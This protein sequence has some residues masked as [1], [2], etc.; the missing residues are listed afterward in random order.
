MR[1]TLESLFFGLAL[2]AAMMAQ[3]PVV[4]NLACAANSGSPSAYA[5]SMPAIPPVYAPGTQYAFQ[6]DVA[7]TGVA[8]INFNSL[9]ARTIK[10]VQGA[11]TADLAANDIRGG[12]WVVMMYDGNNMQMLSQLGNTAGGGSAQAVTVST[13]GGLYSAAYSSGGTISGTGT[14]S[15]GSF[16]GGGSGA[17][18]T[19]NVSSGS[20][21]S[22]TGITAG[23]GYTSA[24]TS[25]TAS[26]GTATCSGTITITSNIAVSVTASGIYRNSTPGGSLTYVLPASSAGLWFDIG[27]YRGVS[28]AVAIVAP[29]S[30]YIAV[31][32]SG[33]SSGGNLKS[34]GALG[35]RVF[36]QAI[37]NTTYEASTSVTSSWSNN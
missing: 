6:A 26:S 31:N 28:G 16:N 10:K 18:A 25:A 30:T 13:S 37:D 19:L 3:N 32:G 1:K 11:V 17:A 5:C 34:G 14:C 35:D 29:S 4:R 23:S 36:L 12:Q 15:L 33:G 8:T 2:S 7:N 27:N 20:V 21:T 22:I 9:G 24:P